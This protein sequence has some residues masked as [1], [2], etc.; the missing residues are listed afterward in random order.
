MIRILGIAIIC[1]VLAFLI[2]VRGHA[3]FKDT[4]KVVMI[5]TWFTLMAILFAIV[6]AVYGGV[7][8]IVHG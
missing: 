8:L 6:M 4:G 3:E 7:V 1:G 5:G 2:C